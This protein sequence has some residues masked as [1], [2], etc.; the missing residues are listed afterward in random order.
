MMSRVLKSG[1]Q[2]EE[3]IIIRIRPSFSSAVNK[4][5]SKN[6]ANGFYGDQPAADPDVDAV[7]SVV[8]NLGAART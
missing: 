8:D 7:E 6:S 3:A 4:S 5:G 2:A 1:E